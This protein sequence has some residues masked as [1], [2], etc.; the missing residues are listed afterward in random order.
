[1]RSWENPRLMLTLDSVVHIS[2]GVSYGFVENEAVLLNKQTNQY[3][4]LEQVGRRFWELLREGKSLRE[5]HQ[6][7]LQEY[8]VEVDQL[9]QDLLE[10]LEDLREH[11]LVEIDEV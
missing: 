11:G 8:E 9:E 6:R 4:V 1:M 7:L 5:S 10:L 2:P 3:Y